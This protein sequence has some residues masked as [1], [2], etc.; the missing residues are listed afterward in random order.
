MPRAFLLRTALMLSLTVPAASL[1]ASEDYWAYSY[2]NID[3]MAA[4]TSAYAINLA[5]YCA[6]LDYLLT[7]ILGIRTTDRIRTQIYAL[8]SAQVAQLL[9]DG[10]RVSYHHSGNTS[11]VVMASTTAQDS[12]YWGAYFGYTASLLASDGRLRGPDWYM[13]GV[14]Q[15]FAGTKYRGTRAQLGIVQSGYAL[16]LGQGSALIPLRTFLAQTKQAVVGDDGHRGELYEAQSWALAH[17]I[18]VEGWHRAEFTRYLD[19]M[20]EG[21]SEA[22]AFSTCF[23][24]SYEQLDKEL[25]LA[26][27]QRPY[28]YTLQVPDDSALNAATAQPLSAAEV[29][30]RVAQLAEQLAGNP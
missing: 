12:E 15:V 28:V 10:S 25:A 27:H 16:T 19:L 29:K 21:T 11:T 14:P 18:Y 4:G 8:P 7:R 22:D 20:R 13:S 17:E 1:A 9:G 5:R 26:I 24:V 2:R 6:R 3:V 30:A 23:K